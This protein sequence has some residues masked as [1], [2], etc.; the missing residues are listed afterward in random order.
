M[1]VLTKA[2]IL[3]VK[4]VLVLHLLPL[5][6]KNNKNNLCN[7]FP[8]FASTSGEFKVFTYIG[9]DTTSND[10]PVSLAVDTRGYLYVCGNT[11]PFSR[12]GESDLG[13]AE[14]SRLGDDDMFL[15]RINAT[16]GEIYWTLRFGTDKEDEVHSLVINKAGTAIYLAGRSYGQL[17][18]IQKNGLTDGFVIKYDVALGGRRLPRLLWKN[19]VVIGT[20]GADAISKIILSE[21]EKS[22][23]AT[24]LSGGK[25]FDDENLGNGDVV[26]VKID[27]SEGKIVR[28]R[29]FGT[30][31][32]D[33][34]REITF[35]S[36]STN[37]PI[38]VA[39]VTERLIGQ[40]K[41]G[42]FHMFKFDRSL[43]SLGS[44]TIKT[45]ADEKI[46]GLSPHPLFPNTLFVTGFSWLD[47]Y[48]ENDLYLKKINQASDDSTNIGYKEVQQDELA[49]PE[50]SARVGSADGGDDLAAAMKIDPESGKIVIAGNTGGSF[51]PTAVNNAP[52]APFIALFD[53]NDGKLLNSAQLN[54]YRSSS[55][56]ELNDIHVNSDQNYVFLSRQINESTQQFFGAV[57]IFYVPTSWKTRIVP[58]TSGPA[59]TPSS[60]PL[61]VTNSTSNDNKDGTKE[62][63]GLPIAIIFG[64]A[65][66]GVVV[67]LAIIAIVICIRVNNRAKK[68]ATLQRRTE[69]TKKKPKKKP[70]KPQPAA[71]IPPRP[72][73][74][75][76]QFMDLPPGTRLGGQLV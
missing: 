59:T 22:L 18:S 4:V 19:P 66:G 3:V 53:P 13:I 50:Y 12:G 65:G 67:L 32:R 69:K 75:P 6:S 74:R 43:N 8:G 54:L 61:D 37:S 58:D 7:A 48:S 15:T 5:Q 44:Y 16:S 23:Y 14:S 2:T 52:I 55:W 21:D 9:S 10:D 46:A 24:G 17:G 35:G 51:A 33:L 63:E 41:I 45:Y 34:G 56:I 26:L 27:A 42:N 31:N 25:M 40:Y 70:K 20:S 68:T 57:G 76:I 60:I 38:Y 64:A 72:P 39:S 11:K 30:S 71:R 73:A 28:G 47:Q 62:S 49:K 1:Y 36:G 29:Q